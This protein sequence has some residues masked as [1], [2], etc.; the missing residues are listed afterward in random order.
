MTT[1]R[2]LIRKSLMDIGALVKNEQ[3]DADEAND[4]LEAL[5]GLLGTWSNFSANIY[6]RA[7][8]TFN[9]TS[10]SSYLI[11]SGQTFN[12]TRPVFIAEA[13]VSSGDIDYPLVITTQETYDSE[14]FKTATGIPQYLVYN[15]NYPYGTITLYPVPSGVQTITILSEKPLTEIATLDTS[16]SFPPGVER[17][18]QKNLAL[19]LAPQYSQ[20]ITPELKEAAVTSLAAIRVA[21]IRNRPINAFPES[22]SIGNIYNGFVS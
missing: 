10:A 8:E 7:R 19:D 13:F 21:V 1:A 2:T 4:A 3:P 15:N 18:L 12:T 17:A 14:S 20:P 5:N 16:L 22:R 11:G 9:L 6:Y